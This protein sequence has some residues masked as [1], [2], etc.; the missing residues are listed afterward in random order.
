MKDSNEKENVSN[1]S[2]NLPKTGEEILLCNSPFLKSY[3]EMH[4]A[5]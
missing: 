1:P 5:K 2:F 3:D 4:D